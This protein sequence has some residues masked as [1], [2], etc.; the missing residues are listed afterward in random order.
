MKNEANYT[1]KLSAIVKKVRQQRGIDPVPELEAMSRLVLGFLQWDATRAIA[2]G[3]HSRITAVMVDN[4][5]LR[6]S[7]T[8]EVVELLGVKYPKAEE[9]AAR[10]HESMQEIY[11]RQHAVSLEH[12]ADKPKKQIRQ[13]LDTL[14]GMTP[15]V[16]AYVALTGFACPSIPV[17]DNLLELLRREDVLDETVGVA[18]AESLFEKVIK[19]EEALETHLALQAWADA[20]V[21]RGGVKE[22]PAAKK[23]AK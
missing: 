17:D 3:A 5:D 21:G 8:H 6:V 20:Q 13:Y 23:P 15:Y 19:E 7:H 16:A 2:K 12:L 4:N 22:K 14:P 11:V 9:R 10:L 1:K 18:D